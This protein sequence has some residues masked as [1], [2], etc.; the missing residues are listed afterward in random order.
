MH[1][2]RFIRIENTIVAPASQQSDSMCSPITDVV[3]PTKRLED[4]ISYAR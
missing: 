4:G 2:S 1:I 3:F